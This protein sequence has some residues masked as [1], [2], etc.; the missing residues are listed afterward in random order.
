MRGMTWRSG[1]GTSAPEALARLLLAAM[2]VHGGWNAFKDPGRRARAAERLRL[3]RPEVM[4]RANGAAMMLGGG[5][6]AIGILPRA[7]AFGLAASL[8]PT[9]LAGH[10]FWTE[11]DEGARRMQTIHFLKNLGLLGG[12]ILVAA[13]P[14]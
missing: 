10:P 12:L 1:R 14:R 13:R 11:D 2:F 6:M 9:T 5:A 3:P 8:V 4:V 7:A